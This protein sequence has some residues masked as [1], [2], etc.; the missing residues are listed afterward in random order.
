MKRLFILFALLAIIAMLSVS[1]ASAQGN[2]QS[3]LVIANGNTNG[4]E[5]RIER[6]G[7]VITNVIPEVGLIVVEASNANFANSVNATV[8]PNFSVAGPQPA[9]QVV[10]DAI[11]QPPFTGDDDT[12][13]D[14]QWGHTAVNAQEAWAAGQTGEGVRV[15]V[16]DEG[17]DMDHPDLLPNLNVGLST[18]FVPLP[19][20]GTP[21]YVLPDTFSHGTHVAGTIAAADNA[22]G[23]IGVAPD[24]ELVFVKVLS[25]IV[26]SG[27]FDWIVEGI[28][29]AANNDADVIN[30]SLGT[31]IEQG[32]GQGSNEI[33]ALRALMN[34]TFSYARQQGAT[35]VVSAGNDALDLDKTGSLINFLGDFPHVISV[36]ATGPVG[37]AL[38]PVGA[39]L[40]RQAS[41]TNIGRSGVDVSGPGGDFVY[42]GNEACALVVVAPCWAF[43]LVFS[44]GNGGWYWSAGTSMAAPHVAGVAAIIIGENGG[45]MHP[46]HV[47]REIERRAQPI[48]GNGNDPLYGA[49]AASTGY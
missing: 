35:V 28:I 21:D 1:V 8:I 20:E 15:F 46:A 49:G 17:F 2:S 45:S 4:L 6:A 33:A 43:D 47:K 14:L 13:F 25:E 37:W 32:Q 40:F 31:I 39:D 41:Y 3:Y 11:P 29:Y 44:T 5:N 48:N 16:L 34:R 9:E 42:P 18:S 24:A 38:D 12:F 30:M 10:A 19:G 36:S 7:G 26:G 22:F 27:Q 23:V